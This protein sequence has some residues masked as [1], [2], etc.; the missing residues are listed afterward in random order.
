VQGYVLKAIE[1]LGG[2]ER[3][4]GVEAEAFIS[5]GGDGGRSMPEETE[6]GLQKGGG[7]SFWRPSSSLTRRRRRRKVYAGGSD[8][9]ESSMIGC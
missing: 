6:E 4:I 2:V 1:E 5:E 8:V 3:Q 9:N 7:G